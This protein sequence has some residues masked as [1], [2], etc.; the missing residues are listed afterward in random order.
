MSLS[1]ADCHA[2]ASAIRRHKTQRRKVEHPSGHL[3]EPSCPRGVPMRN[4]SL[5]AR[6][7]RSHEA[8]SRWSDAMAKALQ[9]RTQTNSGTAAFGNGI[10]AVRPRSGSVRKLNTGNESLV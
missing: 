10:A 2:S 4:G 1:M 5:G 9:G 8:A 6:H 7:D 3:V